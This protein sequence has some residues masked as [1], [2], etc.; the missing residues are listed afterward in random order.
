MT[1]RPIRA[2]AIPHLINVPD[3]TP[4]LGNEPVG[5]GVTFAVVGVGFTTVVLV[6]D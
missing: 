6:V 1:N 4:V 3:S 2:N 5:V